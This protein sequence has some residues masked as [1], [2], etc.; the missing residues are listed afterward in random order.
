[1]ALDALL[2]RFPA[3]AATLPSADLGVRATPLELWRVGGTSLLVKRDDLSAPT[4]GG[5]KVR[6]LE[7]LLAGV[8]PGDVVLTAGATGSTHALSVAHYAA[9]IGASAHVVTWPQREHATSRATNARLRE[10]ASVRDA[11]SVASAYLRILARRIGSRITWVPAGAS[12]P[13]GGC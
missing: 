13:G 9:R 4:L 11:G 3:L 12:V 5:N 7:L 2:R 6:A 8:R 1:V 10:L